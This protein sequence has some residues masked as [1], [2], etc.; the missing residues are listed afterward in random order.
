[1]KYRKKGWEVDNNL[2]FKNLSLDFLTMK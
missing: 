2:V 1:V